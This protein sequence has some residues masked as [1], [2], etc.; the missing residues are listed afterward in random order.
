MAELYVL[1]SDAVLSEST[2]NL[3]ENN[4]ET[5]S[6]GKDNFSEEAFT[7]DTNEI[8]PDDLAVDENLPLEEKILYCVNSELV[9]HRLYACKQIVIYCE[10]QITFSTDFMEKLKS[11]LQILSQ[12]PEHIIREGFAYESLKAFKILLPNGIEEV[13]ESI[14]LR[15]YI[16]GILDD[17]KQAEAVKAACWNCYIEAISFLPIKCQRDMVGEFMRQAFSESSETIIS[18]LLELCIENICLYS[19]KIST[20]AVKNVFE[21]M[22]VRASGDISWIVRNAVAQGISSVIKKVQD[23]I[24]LLKSFQSL[25]SD[26]SVWIPEVIIETYLEMTTL[27]NESKRDDDK[28]S[29]LCAYYFPGVLLTLAKFCA[30]FAFQDVDEVLPAIFYQ[31]LIDDVAQIRSEVTTQISK[32]KHYNRKMWETVISKAEEASKHPNY[33]IRLDFIE[34]AF[35]LFENKDYRFLPQIEALCKDRVKNVR[36]HIA[37]KLIHCKC[38]N[39]FLLPIRT[40]LSNDEDK[41]VQKLLKEFDVLMELDT[42]LVLSMIS[43]SLESMTITKDEQDEFLMDVDLTK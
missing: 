19:E 20:L 22:I 5:I 28:R 18:C 27:E 36:S 7:E 8:T 23:K 2:G 12:D 10:R 24:D 3:V 1:D 32:I 38:S 37:L 30:I 40:I 33:H 43:P 13:L 35:D 41:E 4:K 25:L 15:S 21:P 9:L 26:E 34:I 42:N 6:G 31:L 11:F 16:E 17:R 39:A 14:I 29:Q